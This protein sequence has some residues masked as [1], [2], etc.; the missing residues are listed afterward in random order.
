MLCGVLGEYIVNLGFDVGD[1]LMLFIG[2]CDK[3][4]SMV[5]I[6]IVVWEDVWFS[7]C[8]DLYVCGF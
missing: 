6:S 7:I 8:V 2:L 3:G 1:L 5:V 4:G